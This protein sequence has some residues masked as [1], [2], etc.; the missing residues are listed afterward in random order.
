MEG[1]GDAFWARNRLKPR[2]PDPVIDA[3]QKI[4]ITP[5][6]VL[7]IGCGD[8]WRLEAL[9]GLYPNL[10]PFGVELSRE[11]TTR[12]QERSLFVWK[13][14]PRR[15]GFYDLIVFGFCLYVFD[16]QDLFEWVMKTDEALLDGGHII[17]HDFFPEYPY[18]RPYAHKEGLWSYKMDYRNLW[19]AHPGYREVRTD[20]FGEDDERQ[21]VAVL[22]KDFANAFPVREV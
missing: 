11:A 10:E 16:R 14:L 19:L 7:E 3:I 20:L 13:E 15:K 6:K 4:E 5:T 17:I 2:L 12:A 8:G 21:G 9:R 1:E 22:K 18:R